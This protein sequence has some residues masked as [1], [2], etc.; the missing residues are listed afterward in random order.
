MTPRCYTAAQVMEKLNMPRST[1]FMLKA[2]GKLPF[3]EELL[4]RVGRC[5]RFRADLVDR[6]VAGEWRGLRAMQRVG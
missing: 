2:A 5:A 3:V 6:Y 4:P 1:F